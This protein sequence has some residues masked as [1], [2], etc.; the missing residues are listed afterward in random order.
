MIVGG[1]SDR[2]GREHVRERDV[3][4][5]RTVGRNTTSATTPVGEDVLSSSHD[6]IFTSE[7][8]M[9]AEC[10]GESHNTAATLHYCRRRILRPRDIISS[11]IGY[12]SWNKD[13]A[14]QSTC[15]VTFNLIYFI[16][17]LIFLGCGPVLQ[18]NICLKRD[19]GIGNQY[20]NVKNTSFNVY[21]EPQ[22]CSGSLLFV[23]IIPSLLFFISYLVT[24]IILRFGETEH[25]QTLLERVYLLASCSPWEL[26]KQRRIWCT[27]LAWL[28]AGVAC[29]ACSLASMMLHIAAAKHIPYSFIIPRSKSSKVVLWTGALGLLW[30]QD[31]VVVM[32]V[33][34]YCTQC[35]LLSRLLHITRTTIYQGD[36]PLILIKKQ[37]E[38][39]SRFLRHLNQELGLSVGLFLCLLGFRLT[40][41]A[42]SLFSFLKQ[43]IHP[44]NELVW[45]WPTQDSK[46]TFHLLALVFNLLPWL[47]LTALPLC[48]A[49]RVTSNYRALNKAGSQLHGRP[50]GYQ[51]TPQQDID[52]FL[53]YVTSLHLHAKILWVPVR[54]YFLVSI[55]VLLLMAFIILSYLYF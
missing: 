13:G 28:L 27:F 11:I 53:L 45:L 24:C 19:Q 18:Y 50:F 17:F 43:Y 46:L 40:T 41:G 4:H 42:V 1:R 51:S 6:D 38:E 14:N 8:V 44:E 35:H 12:R 49:A 25:L 23:Y 37:I 22:W 20:T 16:V 52:S 9:I 34:L 3:E 29:L 54:T 26:V 7:A 48:T 47:V 10:D 36:T 55:F 33:L 32:S 30:L 2:A 5:G 15:M 21:E 39:T 31:F